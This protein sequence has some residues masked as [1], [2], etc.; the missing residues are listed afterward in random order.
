MW[1]NGSVNENIFAYSNSVGN[2]RTI[3]FY[4]NKYES[5]SGWIKQSC[6]YAVKTGPG[7]SDVRTE[8]KSLS[9][10]MGLTYGQN[11]FC[12]LWLSRSLTAASVSSG[13]TRQASGL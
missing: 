5:A 1:N 6:E 4:N 9:E 3:V 2:E 11:H 12:I 8:S 13:N 7:E 10:A